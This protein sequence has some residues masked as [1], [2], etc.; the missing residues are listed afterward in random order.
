MGDSYRNA[1]VNE[2]G[3]MNKSIKV[4]K[5]DVYKPNVGRKKMKTMFSK[6]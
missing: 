2:F 4:D 6:N 5:D 1:E 3:I